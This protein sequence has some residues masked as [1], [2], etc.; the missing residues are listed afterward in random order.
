MSNDA[1]DTLGVKTRML[2]ESS[3]Q[4]YDGDWLQS[5]RNVP[6]SSIPPVGCVEHAHR[7]SVPKRRRGCIKFEVPG[8][9][10][11]F[12][13]TKRLFEVLGT[14]MPIAAS[15]ESETLD[16]GDSRQGDDIGI[17]NIDDGDLERAEEA[18][19][20]GEASQPDC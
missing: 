17:A 16:K 15:V 19:L 6:A 4:Y 12:E 11:A 10:S 14:T 1:I 13:G 20:A 3:I 7:T 8:R 9:A 2:A 5:A 18:L